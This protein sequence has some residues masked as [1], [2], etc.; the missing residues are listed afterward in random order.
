MGFLPNDAKNIL[1]TA[2][3]SQSYIYRPA[4]VEHQICINPPLKIVPNTVILLLGLLTLT[5]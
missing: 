2:A 4:A 5:D 3:L 1:P